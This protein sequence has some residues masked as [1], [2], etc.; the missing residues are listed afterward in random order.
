MRLR[1]EPTPDGGIGLSVE[2]QG[3]GLTETQR[4]RMFA[5]FQRVETMRLTR[6]RDEGAGLGLPIS[7]RLAALHDAELDVESTLGEGTE[8]KVVFPPERVVGSTS[9][10]DGGAIP[11]RVR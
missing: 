10:A 3:P 9:P 8:I 1:A 7:Q 5:P 11:T 4:R 2:D 6:G